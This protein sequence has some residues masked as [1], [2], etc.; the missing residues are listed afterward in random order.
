MGSFE[1][2]HPPIPGAPSIL[3]K[4]HTAHAAARRVQSESIVR[5]SLFMS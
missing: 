5:T 3:P 2:L 4:V 1:D